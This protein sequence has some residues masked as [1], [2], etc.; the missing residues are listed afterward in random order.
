MTE[1]I[2]TAEGELQR[3][4]NYL[5]HRIA[6]IEAEMVRLQ[7]RKATMEEIREQLIQQMKELARRNTRD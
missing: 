1:E 2:A 4:H 5:S 7:H 6:L 3:V